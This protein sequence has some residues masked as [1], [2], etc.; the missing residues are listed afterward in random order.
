MNIFD[1]FIIFNNGQKTYRTVTKTNSA[2]KIHY[3]IFVK[4][5]EA[6]ADSDE[7]QSQLIFYS[8]SFELC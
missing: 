6:E 1:I 5:F 8:Q 7:I 2:Q 4:I 3:S